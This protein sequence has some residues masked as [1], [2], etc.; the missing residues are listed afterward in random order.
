MQAAA[1]Q[2]FAGF[3]PRLFAPCY[4]VFG[5]SRVLV[6]G[7]DSSLPFDCG[8]DPALAAGNAE[9]ALTWRNAMILSAQVPHCWS[10]Q[11]RLRY[12]VVSSP[13]MAT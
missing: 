8:G 13:S 12:G 6:L 9:R 5:P 4:A 11:I 3:M 10:G 7:P 2:P 1:Y